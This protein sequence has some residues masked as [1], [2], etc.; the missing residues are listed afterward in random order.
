MTSS[1]FNF[2]NN[3]LKIIENNKSTITKKIDTIT[4]EGLNKFSKKDAN[5]DRIEI[6]EEYISYYYIYDKNN[7]ITYFLKIEDD[8]TLYIIRKDN[9]TQPS[10]VKGTGKLIFN[11]DKD[12]KNPWILI[13]R[14]DKKI[15]TNTNT[16][17]YSN[18]PDKYKDIIAS[19]DNN[20][21]TNNL[22][23]IP[24]AINKS[25]IIENYNIKYQQSKSFILNYDDTKNIK[26]TIDRS[27][28]NNIFI[29]SGNG[30]TWIQFKKQNLRNTRNTYGFLTLS[31]SSDSKINK[32]KYYNRNN[33]DSDPIIYFGN[34]VLYSSSFNTLAEND[35]V[36]QDVVNS[37]VNVYIRSGNQYVIN[38][39]K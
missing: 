5:G 29:S 26:N 32:V 18:I 39:N 25:N 28:T 21:E 3:E 9:T 22:K 14:I 11:E 36:H 17:I 10:I 34:E 38:L 35:N 24:Q 2:E 27:N 31:S 20:D 16:N 7:K 33:N 13:R 37:G 12:N 1:S 23:I 19:M 15:T 8:N 4:I 30:N 6:E